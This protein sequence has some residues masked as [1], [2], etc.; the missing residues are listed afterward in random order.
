MMPRN[1]FLI[2]PCP[3]K[4]R[5]IDLIRRL[6][7]FFYAIKASCVPKKITD[8]CEAYRS[9]YA[10]APLLSSRLAQESI[11]LAFLFWGLGILTQ[12][13]AEL[14]FALPC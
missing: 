4:T 2:M 9:F 13:L 14:A 1:I 3:Q 10:A 7:R 11:C 5:G 12:R 6:L 8:H